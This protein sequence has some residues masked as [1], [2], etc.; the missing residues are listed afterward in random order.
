MTG[1]EEDLKKTVFIGL[2]GATFAVLDRMMEEGV[3]P[4]LKEFSANGSRAELHSTSNPLT[5]PAWIS[6]VTGKG[7][8]DHGIFDFLRPEEKGGGIVMKLNDSKDIKSETVWSIASRQGKRIASL[9]FYGMSPAQPVSGYLVSGFI[10]WKHLKRATYPQEFYETMKSL[11]GVDIK[12]L[13]FHLE[14]EKKCFQGGKM[15][16]AESL[17]WIRSHIDRERNW[18]KILSHIMQNDPCDLTAVVFDGVDKLQHLF[19]PYI[20]GE[21]ACS[22]V[23]TP[24]QKE[25]RELCLDYYRAIDRYISE[26]VAMA[27][28]G[29]RVFIASDHGFGTTEEIFY[30]NKWLHDHGVLEWSEPNNIAEPGKL[31]EGRISSHTGVIDFNKT[32]AYCWTPSSNGIYIR[33][34]IDGG[35]G[36]KPEEYEGFREG[37]RKGLLEYVDPGTGRRPVKSVLTR[38]EAFPGRYSHLAPDL[39]VL[40]DD[41]GMVSILNSDKTLKKR[42]E[43]AGCHRLEGVFIAGGEGIKKGF[44]AD[45]FSIEDVAPCLLYSLGLPVPEDMQG[46]VPSAVFED[47]YLRTCPIRVEGRTLGADCSRDEA[48]DSADSSAVMSQLRM[49][50][51]IE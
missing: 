3:M 29:A 47:D 26:A 20:F 18:F 8:G 19:W 40:M 50:G 21:L 4:F 13:G 14:Q 10:P 30:L 22:T 33:R 25:I 37:I 6:L 17:A 11:D 49:L 32:L 42:D 28:P 27:G 45:A 7:P 36:V 12:S 39:T 34:S 44:S 24:E 41:G 2:D 38:E 31:T 15:D 48:L 23:V 46:R 35:P 1:T 5:P 43:P 16:H 51:Y 9:N